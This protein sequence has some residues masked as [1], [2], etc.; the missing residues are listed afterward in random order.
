M[1]LA[2]RK[3]P[4]GASPAWHVYIVRTRD[5]SFYTGVTTNVRRRLS[6]HRAGAGRGARYLRG[7]TPLKIVYRCRIG[8]RGLAHR[9]EWHLKRRTRAEKQ[10]IVDRRPSRRGLLQR[11]RAGER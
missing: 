9:V 1:K 3:A 10:A 6:E 5:G 7:R 2:A 11:V 8:D 4:D